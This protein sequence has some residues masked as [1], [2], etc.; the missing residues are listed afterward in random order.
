[1]PEADDLKFLKKTNEI[2]IRSEKHTPLEAGLMETMALDKSAM[3]DEIYY[4]F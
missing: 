4:F 1:V 2:R 3:P